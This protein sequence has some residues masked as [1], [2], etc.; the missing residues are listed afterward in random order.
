MGPKMVYN[1]YVGI[2]DSGSIPT[3]ILDLRIINSTD[4]GS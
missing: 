2:P 4:Q 1:G 3:M